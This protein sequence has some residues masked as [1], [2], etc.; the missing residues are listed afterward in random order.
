[1]HVF[2]EMNTIRD[3]VIDLLVENDKLKDDMQTI[4]ISN[5][6]KPLTKDVLNSLPKTPIGRNPMF[7]V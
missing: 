6:F 5:L 4:V 7:E 3:D 1:M 2:K